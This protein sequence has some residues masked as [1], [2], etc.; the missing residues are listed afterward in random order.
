VTCS[1]CGPMMS[2][3]LIQANYSISFRCHFRFHDSRPTLV[4]RSGRFVND[5]VL[6]HS[7]LGLASPKQVLGHLSEMP[8]IRPGDENAFS[9]YFVC[10]ASPFPHRHIAGC[11]KSALLGPR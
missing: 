9:G 8:T 1:I 2:V 6:Y 3:P 5:N 11:I 10:P 7:L 4:H